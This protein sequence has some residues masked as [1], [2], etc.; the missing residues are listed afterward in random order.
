MSTLSISEI[1]YELTASKIRFQE[2][3]IE[4]QSNGF[5]YY[6]KDPFG[7]RKGEM[8]GELHKKF[9]EKIA[10]GKRLDALSEIKTILC[11]PAYAAELFVGGI[12]TKAMI[13]SIFEKITSTDGELITLCIIPNQEILFDDQKIVAKIIIVNSFSHHSYELIDGANI[14]LLW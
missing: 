13:L 7:N 2:V 4:K 9:M 11:N 8:I 12:I 6:S 3:V 10:Q 14:T 5:W 1:S